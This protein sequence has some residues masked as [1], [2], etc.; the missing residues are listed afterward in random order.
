VASDAPTTPGGAAPA[1]DPGVHAP[2]RYEL[3]RRL[4]E[5]GMGVVWEA[6]DR[7]LD[8][9]VALKFLHDELFGADLQALLTDEARAMARLSH[10]HVVTVFDVGEDGGRT[11]IAME[12]VRGTTLAR[13]LQGGR[14]WR[15]VVGLF[16]GIGRGLAAAHAAG[17]V[18]R[19]IKPGNILVGDDG[20]ARIADFGIAAIGA[21]RDRRD[22]RDGRGGTTATGV[23][24]TPLYMAP[25]RLAG[26]RADFKG[27]QYSFAAT[28]YEALAGRPPFDDDGPRGEPAPIAGVPPWL[29]AVVARGLSLDPRDRF[30]DLDAFVAALAPPARRWPWVAAGAVALG[31]AAALVIATQGGGGPDRCSGSEA[32]LAAAWSRATREAIVARGHGLG[33]LAGGQVERAVAALD[34]AGKTWVTA[35]RGACRARTAGELPPALYERRLVCLAHARASIAAAGEVLGAATRETLPD[36]VVAAHAV[37]DRD[38]CSG[39]GAADAPPP[40]ELAARAAEIGD[41][42]ARARVM[43]IAVHPDAVT[44]AREGVAAAEA[45]GFAP[46]VARARLVEGIALIATDPPAAV[47]PLRLA[48]RAALELGDDALGVEAYARAVYALGVDPEHVG[49]TDPARE[50][51]GF[52]VME[53]IAGRLTGR[54]AFAR[55]LFFNNAGLVTLAAGDRAAAHRWLDKALTEVHAGVGAG[56]HELAYV[57]ANL[58][59]A[60]DDVARRMQLFAEA[61]TGAVAALGADHPITL[62]L[63]ELEALAIADPGAAAAA[64]EPACTGFSELYPHLTAQIS[65]CWYERAWLAVDRGDGATAAAAF[66]RVTE[67]EALRA[68]ATEYVALDRDPLGAATRLAALG[69]RDRDATAWWLHESA[70][71]AFAAA[72]TGFAR[73]GR[74]TRARECLEAAVA[75]LAKVEPFH[76]IANTQRRIARA[77]ARLAGALAGTD[78][79]RARALATAAAAW[80]RAAG[81]HADDLAALAAITAGSP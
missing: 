28:L 2:S 37:D 77:R 46:L 21:G 4:G 54:A 69:E 24:G 78:P 32:E 34:R 6:H 72:A 52:G 50:L 58:A 45:L 62:G 1:A 59:L 17:I 80:Y 76:P 73:A 18:H 8:R 70:G 23:T 61:R 26:A 14:G 43:A 30:A 65:E 44:A 38:D 12:L 16:L 74:A 5:G 63:Q 56:E 20:R 9:P 36:A 25:E 47:E 3:G 11:Y 53:P 71:D 81:G 27:D 67:D 41:R 19:D 79:A 40:P 66:A 13:W 22:G 10:P 68:V 48:T 60:T 51:G 75:V 39:Y 33:A 15:E 42:V 57:P 49:A 35:H 31:G 29:S 55:V 7:V 64:L